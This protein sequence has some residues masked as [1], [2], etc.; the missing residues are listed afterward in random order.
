VSERPRTALALCLLLVT[1]VALLPAAGEASVACAALGPGEVRLTGFGPTGVGFDARLGSLFYPA[2]E[3]NG[4]AATIE[5]MPGDCTPNT[6]VTQA[7]YGTASGT[8]AAPDD[9]QETS[10]TTVVLCG[11]RDTHPELCPPGPPQSEQVVVPTAEDALVESAVESL[12]FRLIGGTLGV[13]EPSSAPVHV[14]DDDGAVRASL[15]PMVGQ[16]GAVA[17][18]RSETYSPILIPVFLAGPS[19]GGSVAYSVEPSPG[20]HAGIGEDVQVLSPNPLPV[21][22]DRVGYIELAIANDEIGEQPESV[23]VTLVPGGTAAV[24]SPSSTTM[25][26][27]DNEETKAPTSRI[28]HPRDGWRYRKSDYRIREIHVFT[29]DNPGGAGVVAAQLALRRNMKSGAC[30]WLAPGGWVK[31]GCDDRTWLQM[32]YEEPADLWLVSVR[33]LRSSVHTRIQDYT[34]FSRAV[35]GA[36]NVEQAF[37]GKRNANDFEIKRS[38]KRR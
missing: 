1:A 25:T 17:Y 5:A 19:A 14:I 37:N 36:G 21:G 26:I 4:A 22:A 2:L 16:A 3:G 10:G 30:A 35:D 11:D 32:I 9:F 23:T 7:T 28:H 13:G 29:S 27:L 15:E 18:E 31:Q 20:S 8:A 24:A 6:S 38:K 34:V 33:Q 12:S